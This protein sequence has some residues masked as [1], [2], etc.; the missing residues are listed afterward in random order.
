[1]RACF[2]EACAA[3]GFQPRIAFEASD[4]N[5]LAQLAIRGARP[6][7]RPRLGRAHLYS[8]GRTYKG[9]LELITITR[10]RMRGRLAIAWREDGLISPAAR[11]FIEY[12]VTTLG[13]ATSDEGPVGP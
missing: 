3:A 13:A 5:V 8:V 10:P 2:D 7:H 12:A 6:G 1:M 11:A 4:P 9:E